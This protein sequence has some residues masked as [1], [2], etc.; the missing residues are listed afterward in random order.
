MLSCDCSSISSPCIVRLRSVIS[1]LLVWIISVLEATS[2]FSSSVYRSH[3]REVSSMGLPGAQE[4]GERP[5]SQTHL[6]KEP[7]LGIPA[8][9]LRHGL[10]LLPHF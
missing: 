7:S 4:A 5:T 6:A 10:I 1:V 8:V 2:L 9:L 3:T